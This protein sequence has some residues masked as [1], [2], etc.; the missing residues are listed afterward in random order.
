MKHALS[1][2]C[3]D[4][5]EQRTSTQMDIPLHARDA[6]CFVGAELSCSMV[7][8]L[9]RASERCGFPL[10]L[11]RWQIIT[12]KCYLPHSIYYI[13]FST[14]GV[15]LKCSNFSLFVSN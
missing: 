15:L 10:D 13:D 7:L 8:D 1:D 3:V 9:V 4:E 11:L 14:P 2:A 5:G 12:V 6:D